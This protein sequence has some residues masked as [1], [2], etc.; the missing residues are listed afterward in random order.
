MENVQTDRELLIA[1]VNR[2][3]EQAPEK[4]LYLTHVFLRG[5]GYSDPGVEGKTAQ[6]AKKAQ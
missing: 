1:A 2:Q 4:L 3:M 5:W 6:R